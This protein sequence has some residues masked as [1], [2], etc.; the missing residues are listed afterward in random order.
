MAKKVFVSGCFDILHSGH[1]AFFEEASAYGDLYVAL[2]SDQTVFKLKGRLP[3]NNEDERL[4]MVRSVRNVKDAFVSKGSGMLDFI[5]EFKEVKPDIM[6]VNTDGHMPEKQ[7]L[8]AK[9]GVE[10]IVLQ[11]K[12]HGVLPPRSTTDLRTLNHMPFRIDLAGGWQDQPFVSDHYPGDVITIS[13][14]PT[15]DFNERSGMAS[16]TR[17]AAIELWGS[18]LPRGNYEKLAKIL[19]CYDNPPGTKV[20]SGSQD[21]IGIVYPGLA[22]ATY[23]GGYWPISIE[24]VL[25]ETKL[26]F[27]ESSLYLVMLGP[28]ED[29]YDVLANTNIDKEN[30]K[31]LAMATDQCWNAIQKQD[32]QAFGASIRETFE[33]Q[34]AMFPNML[35]ASGKILIDKYR[36]IALG[37]KMSGAGGGGYLILVSD[38]PI[39]NASQIYIR[40]AID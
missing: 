10:Y 26:Q 13:L 19:F 3:I 22:R 24:H 18:R 17:R 8:C 20:I 23:K 38:S 39:E 37:W 29:E 31:A 2:G 16:S 4:F 9:F 35:T 14:E 7:E 5:E 34:V 15:I 12:P 28:R 36:D 1:I 6:V 25:D 27:I 32:V 40:R 21:S 11:R 33:A 30:A